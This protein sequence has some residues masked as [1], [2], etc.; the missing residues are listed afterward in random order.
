MK[1]YISKKTIR[2]LMIFLGMIILPYL[3]FGLEAYSFTGHKFDSYN[4][5]IVWIESHKTD[6]EKKLITEQEKEE[7]LSL[8]QDELK[9]AG[10]LWY[11]TPFTIRGDD[12]TYCISITDFGNG[13]DWLIYVSDKPE[14]SYLRCGDAFG[15][16]FAVNYE[17]I[18]CL[19][20]FI[21]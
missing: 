10:P 16:K 3:W 21:G 9:Y 19:R 6:T 7:V 17:V 1:K 14:Y 5:T 8:L 15:A 12:E 4:S 11:R 2:L 18:E 13:G 20:E